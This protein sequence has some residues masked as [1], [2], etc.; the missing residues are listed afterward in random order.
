MHKSIMVFS[1]GYFYAS[2]KTEDCCLHEL[3]SLH[4]AFA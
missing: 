2:H 1:E 3:F 4:F